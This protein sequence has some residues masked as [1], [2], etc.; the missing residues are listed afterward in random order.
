[1][2]LYNK[3]IIPILSRPFFNKGVLILLLSTLISFCSDPNKGIRDGVT[4]T[5]CVLEENLETIGLVE[6]FSMGDP[7]SVVSTGDKIIVFNKQ[8]QQETV[9]SKTGR[10]P[11][12]YVTASIVRHYGDRI[13]VWCAYSLRF[14]VYN[15]NGEGIIECRYDSAISDFIPDGDNLYIYTAGRR[16]EHMIDVLNIASGE[17]VDSIGSPSKEHEVLLMQASSAPFAL[18]KDNLYFMPKDSLV[19][20]RYSLSNRQLERYQELITP[21]FSVKTFNGS[22]EDDMLKAVAFTFENSFTVGLAINNERLEI[23]TTEGSARINVHDTKIEDNELFS[24]YYSVDIGSSKYNHVKYTE[25]IKETWVSS[26]N[27]SLFALNLE[28]I[29]DNDEY[30]ICKLLQ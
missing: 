8:G 16:V 27:G 15:M 5:L 20:Y 7:F 9:I 14:I 11:F 17:I 26:Y 19:V 23:L 2:I 4:D 12:E 3:K 6:S 29:D 18:Y 21:S 22:I 25:P 28:I 1:M 13:Y 10:G 24:S 30:S